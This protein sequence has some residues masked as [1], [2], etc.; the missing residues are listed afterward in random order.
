MPKKRPRRTKGVTVWF[1]PEEYAA[2][3][4]RAAS[5]QDPVSSWVRKLTVRELAGVR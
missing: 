2:L 5:E 1:T 3:G 4:T